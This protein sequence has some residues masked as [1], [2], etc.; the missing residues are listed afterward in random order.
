MKIKLKNLDKPITTPWCF[1]NWGYCPDTINKLN[2]GKQVVVD[3]VP[4]PT[5]EY[6][7]EVKVNKT[8][9]KNKKENK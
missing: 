7:E 4:K 5:W 9:K 3:K 6:V 2:S 1:F 8:K